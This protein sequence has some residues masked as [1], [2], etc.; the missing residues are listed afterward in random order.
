[1]T[2]MVGSPIVAEIDSWYSLVLADVAKVPEHQRWFFKKWLSDFLEFCRYRNVQ[3]SDKQALDRYL[4]GLMASGRRGFQVEQA[5][6]AVL[7]YWLHAEKGAG[8]ERSVAICLGRSE[9]AAASGLS[10]SLP[11][12]GGES[13][14][15]LTACSE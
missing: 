11:A 8:S 10:G 14:E 6:W 15:W 2:G 12:D 13:L 4:D 9:G 7:L 3:D 1:M 5:R